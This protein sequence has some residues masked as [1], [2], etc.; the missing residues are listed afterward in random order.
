MS[1]TQTLPVRLIQMVTA[2]V[3]LMIT[4]RLWP[5]RLRP[6]QTQT[7]WAMP[8]TPAPMMR[9]MM[10]TLTGSAVTWTTARLWQTPP[11][12]IADAD[13]IGDVCDPDSPT[14]SANDADGDGVCGDN[15]NCP[16]VANP[17]Q[18]DA[19]GDGLGDACDACPNDA[20]N[21]ADADGVCG[22]VDN[23]PAIAN[24]TQTDADGDGLGDACDACPNDAA[25]DADA[26]GVC[27]DV[28]NCPADANASQ[29]DCDADLI[30][31]AC[32]PDSP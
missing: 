4:A 5:T 16:A 31:D 26:D 25:N 30:G 21:D 13:L 22:D 14:D 28:D 32:D 17:T 20:A 27:G 3:I 23:C 29:A 11:R 12:R 6:M 1:A 15:D 7:V 2:F 18:T 8:A 24:P 9:P 10:R 19:D